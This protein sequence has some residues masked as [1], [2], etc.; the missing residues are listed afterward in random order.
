MP[1]MK[2]TL[3]A[4]MR[5]RDVSRSR[6]E[7]EEATELPRGPRR[8]GP[9]PA[10]EPGSSRDERP[11]APGRPREGGQDSRGRAAAGGRGTGR[12][13]RK[14][15]LTPPAASTGRV[16]AEPPGLNRTQAE[17]HPR[18]PARPPAPAP[19]PANGYPAGPGP[20]GGIGGS[21]PDFS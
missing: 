21:S 7:H 17:P 3:S 8:S 15:R 9:P 1:G 2:V 11:A 4:A 18:Q 19:A 10:P 14:R 13:R 5:A 16:A 20:A 12:P 6:A